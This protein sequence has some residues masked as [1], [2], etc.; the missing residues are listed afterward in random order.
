MIEYRDFRAPT[1]AGATALANE[2]LAQQVDSRVLNVETLSSTGAVR[3]W[4][5][6]PAR[7]EVER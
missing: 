1:T 4:I 6:R 2:W 7:Q 5:T 3:V